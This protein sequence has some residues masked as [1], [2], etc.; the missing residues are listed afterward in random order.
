[1]NI[2]V[3]FICYLYFLP[4]NPVGKP[5]FHHRCIMKITGHVNKYV[6]RNV[7]LPELFQSQQQL[8]AENLKNY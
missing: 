4:S 7:N 1:M 2:P 6:T 5:H 3:F 8:H